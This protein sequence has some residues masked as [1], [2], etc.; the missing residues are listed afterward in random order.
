MK[1]II[2]IF[3][4]LAS[5]FAVAQNDLKARLEFEEAEKSFADN[6]FEEAY[7]KLEK[8]QTLIG[9]WA[10]NIS[11]LKIICL[12]V[13]NDYSYYKGSY[14]KLLAKEVPLYMK[15]AN[16]HKDA[17]VMDKFKEVY[18]IEEKIK[19]AAQIEKD[20]NSPEFLILETNKSEDI[21][22]YKKV[23]NKGN[24]EAMYQVGYMYKSGKGVAMD[25]TEAMNWYTKAADKDNLN[26]MIGI[27]YTYVF[28]EV[29]SNKDYT[30]AILWFKKAAEKGSTPAMNSLAYYYNEDEVADYT[31][32]IMWYKKLELKGGGVACSSI[33]GFY[34]YGKGV[35]K[36]YKEAMYWYKKGLD[37]TLKNKWQ[38]NITDLYYV[39]IAYLY[40]EG[41]YGI[42][43][44][45]DEAIK[46]YKL[47][48]DKGSELAMWELSKMYG[49]GEGVA[50]DKKIAKE[51]SDKAKLAK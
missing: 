12:D 15:F 33:G 39:N 24:A 50:E 10:P 2:L 35:T 13:I 23:A 16:E 25:K 32:S 45:Y 20:K 34:K 22:Q 28:G 38:G 31:Q 47:A 51:W 26:A 44:N 1:K 5:N 46:F 17:V 19:I 8:T 48:A 29:D 42:I 9:K 30:Q 14:N 7:A 18:A 41:G 11:Y 4:I 43:Q 49:V 37:K 21:E 27:A 3:L 40:R 6:N 36:D